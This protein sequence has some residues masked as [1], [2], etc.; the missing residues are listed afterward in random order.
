MVKGLNDP[1][2]IVWLKSLS[3]S[4]AITSRKKKRNMDERKR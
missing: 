4:A 3:A 2:L 1:I